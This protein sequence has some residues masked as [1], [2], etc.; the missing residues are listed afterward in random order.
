MSNKLTFNT[1]EFLKEIGGNRFLNSGVIDKQPVDNGL[2]CETV[3]DPSDPNKAIFKAT[4]TIKA[5]QK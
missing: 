5:K 2:V 4:W 1:K 3:I